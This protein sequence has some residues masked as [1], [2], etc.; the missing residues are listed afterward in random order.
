MAGSFLLWGLHTA[1]NLTNREVL[2]SREAPLLL[3]RGKLY[4]R[5][6]SCVAWKTHHTMEY[7][8]E[9]L[10]TNR[11]LHSNPAVRPRGEDPGV[12]RIV[13]GEALRH[14]WRLPRRWVSVGDLGTSL[15]TQPAVLIIQTHRTGPLLALAQKHRIT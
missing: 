8:E 13:P 11:R 1:R 10:R 6:P 7:G 14:P 12:N 15:I 9:G 4:L 3:S 2:A 5:G